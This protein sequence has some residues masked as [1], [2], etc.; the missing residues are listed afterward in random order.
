MAGTVLLD[1]TFQSCAREHTNDHITTDHGLEALS[2]LMANYARP[3]PEVL[4]DLS[5]RY[6]SGDEFRHCCLGAITSADNPFVPGMVLSTRLADAAE[7]AP[8]G[9]QRT[10]SD[11]QK[12]VDELLLEIFERLPQ[13]V[14][15]FPGG[16]SACTT[17]FCPGF[18]KQGDEWEDFEGPLDL[19]FSK[20][21]QRCTFC[22]LPLVIDFLSQRFTL[23]LPNLRDTARA[24]RRSKELEHLSGRDAGTESVCLLLGRKETGNDQRE[25]RGQMQEENMDKVGADG[26]R[27]HTRLLGP[28]SAFASWTSP[29][30]LLQ[31]ANCHFPSLTLLPGLQ[32]SVAGLVAKPD[33]FYKV[34]LMRLILDVVVFLATITAL[35]IFVLFN[36]SKDRAKIV[37]GKTTKRSSSEKLGSESLRR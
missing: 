11:I 13:T 16:M 35:S 26:T 10:I 12:S 18:E 6:S 37:D 15:A 9:E 20:E 4:R 27:P 24:L 25:R 8:E 29:R 7:Q 28:G 3:S 1:D 33:E 30:A 32:F 5:A 19:I 14:R 34:P 23:G 31:G 17:I 36:S 21:E 22:S 2:S